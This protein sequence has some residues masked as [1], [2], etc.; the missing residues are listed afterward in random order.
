MKFFGSI[1][2][3]LLA[4]MAASLSACSKESLPALTT[5]EDSTQASPNSLPDSGPAS[6]VESEVLQTWAQSVSV[7]MPD[8]YD[9]E[10]DMV[11]SPTCT[12]DVLKNSISRSDRSSLVSKG[13]NLQTVS[14]LSPL[15]GHLRL[16]FT[17]S[18]SQVTALLRA[19][20]GTWWMF[21]RKAPTQSL[22]IAALP[23]CTQLPGRDLSRALT[24][25]TGDL[26]RETRNTIKKTHVI[27]VGGMLLPELDLMRQAQERGSGLWPLIAD[28]GTSHIDEAFA[29]QFR[30]VRSWGATAEIILPPTFEAPST[31]IAAVVA[32]I[33]ASERPVVIF[34]QSKG[35]MTVLKALIARPDLQPKVV[36]WIANAS[37]FRGKKILGQL[38]TTPAGQIVIQVAAGLVGGESSL[39]NEFIAPAAGPIFL[40]KDFTDLAL[41]VPMVSTVDPNDVAVELPQGIL[42]GSV[43]VQLPP[44]PDHGSLIQ[45]ITFRGDAHINRVGLSN[46]LFAVLVSQMRAINP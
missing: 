18:S 41:R 6:L 26:I 36:G 34:S 27:F 44:M 30:I 45:G 25:L 24:E 43:F 12:V 39:A 35:G 40:S 37:P 9:A 3:A 29:D 1:G 5:I 7:E 32:A 17:I 11:Y 46:A 31:A 38:A 13:Y 22:V 2:W 4:S 20:S 15:T 19:A 28:K 33:E 21:E 16:S 8:F 10:F 42:P 14:K 23:T